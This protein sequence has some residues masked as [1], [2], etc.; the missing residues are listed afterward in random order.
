M[1]WAT[2][3]DAIAEV[4]ASVERYRTKAAGAAA[5]ALPEGG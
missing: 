5:R 2:A 4:R 3:Q 1:G